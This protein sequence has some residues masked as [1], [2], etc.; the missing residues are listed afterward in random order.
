MDEGGSDGTVEDDEEVSYVGIKCEGGC[1]FNE[2][3][4][5]RNV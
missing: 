1:P 3:V 2:E 4:L 5:G